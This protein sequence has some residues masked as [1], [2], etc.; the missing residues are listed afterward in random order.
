[1]ILVV[2]LS[3]LNFQLQFV[4]FTH[5]FNLVILLSNFETARLEFS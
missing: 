2:C 4:Y 1:M 3:V 5:I